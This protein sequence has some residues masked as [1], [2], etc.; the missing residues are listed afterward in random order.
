[1]NSL[2]CRWGKPSNSGR[3]AQIGWKEGRGGGL[4]V[5][6]GRGRTHKAESGHLNKLRAKLHGRF[7]RWRRR[8]GLN[9]KLFCLTKWKIKNIKEIRNLWCWLV[10]SFNIFFFFFLFLMVR[11]KYRNFNPENMKKINHIVKWIFICV[12]IF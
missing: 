10:R 6:G 11:K 4:G 9:I 12:I 7:C 2:I 1:M 3:K 5:R 8:V